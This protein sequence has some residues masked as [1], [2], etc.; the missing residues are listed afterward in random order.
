MVISVCYTTPSVAFSSCMF[1]WKKNVGGAISWSIPLAF[2]NS[3]ISPGAVIKIAS[4][5]SSMPLVSS[6]TLFFFHL[7]GMACH[8]LKYFRSIQ[9]IILWVIISSSIPLCS[10]A[11]YNP[12]VSTRH[13][14]SSAVFCVN[15]SST[16]VSISSP[17]FLLRAPMIISALG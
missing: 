14:F 7:L 3:P 1:H 13:M 16:I 8:L 10:A 6:L 4:F 17:S 15:V 11:E 9:S 5:P 2:R 12:I